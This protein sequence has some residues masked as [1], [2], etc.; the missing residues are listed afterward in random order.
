MKRVLPLIVIMAAT[1]V[2]WTWARSH[3]DTSDR[4]AVSG[5]IELRQYEVSFKIAGRLA[6]I[7][8]NEGD[9]VRKGALLARIAPEQ[10]EQSRDREAASLRAAE[11]QLL[12]MKTA[13]DYQRE[14]NAGEYEWREAELRQA[15]AQLNQL[16]AGSRTQEIRQADSALEEA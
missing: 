8:V 9:T 2:Y 15:Q 6:E 4:I 7:T 1:G 11:L 14:A 12:Q 16:L 10:L 3:N 5:N 13:V